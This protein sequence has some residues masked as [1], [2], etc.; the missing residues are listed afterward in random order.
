[1]FVDNAQWKPVT[2]SGK[3]RETDDFAE[4]YVVGRWLSARLEKEEAE[5]VFKEVDA[6]LRGIIGDDLGV[7]TSFAVAKLSP[8]KGRESTDWES[9]FANFV[10]ALKVDP[11]V[12]GDGVDEVA[13]KVIERHTHTGKPYRRLVVKEVKPKTTTTEETK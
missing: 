6:K 7:R 8:V 12:R 11:L 5:A 9:A 13:A 2:T 4:Q 1:V 10:S 3:V